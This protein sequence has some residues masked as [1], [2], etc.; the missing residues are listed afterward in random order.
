M[1]ASYPVEC[2]HESCHWCGDLVPSLLYGDRRSEIASRQEA[3][4]EC[5]RC[6]RDWEVHLID[7]IV[8]VLPLADHSLPDNGIETSAERAFTQ[9]LPKSEK[10]GNVKVVTFSPGR[11]GAV[12][13]VLGSQLAT[14]PTQQEGHILLDFSNVQFITSAELGTLVSLHKKLRD[15]G[16]RLTLFNLNFPVFEVFTATHLERLLE[17]CR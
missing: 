16:G 17:I 12:E 2:P 1:L 6:H 8:T 11:I 7:N 4:F 14:L 5:P 9:A 13:D 3:Q 10:S 15:S